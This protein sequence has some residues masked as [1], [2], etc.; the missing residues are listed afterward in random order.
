MDLDAVSAERLKGVYPDLA[1][2]WRRVAEDMWGAH[3][4]ALRVSEGIRS[5]EAQAALYAKGR[6]TPGAIVT[7]S[8]PGES[9]HHY[10][11]ALDSC[12]LGADPFLEKEPRAELYWREYGRFATAHGLTWGGGWSRFVDRPHVQLAYGLTLTQIKEIYS[13]KGLD[14]VWAKCD[15][16]RGVDVGTD[17]KPAVCRPISLTTKSISS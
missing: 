13:Y 2:R 7:Y 14:S 15:Q 3:R 8:K 1:V 4:R 6:T 9:F 12:F 5:L 16:M 10:G 17:W 11:L